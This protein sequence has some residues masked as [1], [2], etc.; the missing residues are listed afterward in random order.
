MDFT[1]EEATEYLRLKRLLRQAVEEQ[2]SES[3]QEELQSQI[4]S[5]DHKRWQM[6]VHA[7]PALAPFTG[8]VEALRYT[9]NAIGVVFPDGNFGDHSTDRF[10]FCISDGYRS[11]QI[12]PQVGSGEYKVEL[13]DYGDLNTDANGRCY[14]GYTASLE[15][16]TLVLCRWLVDRWTIDDLHMRCPWLPNVLLGL[17]QQRL[18]LGNG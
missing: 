16:A 6:I 1:R 15:D 11:V 7:F 14:T 18:F 10:S 2:L 13:F 8:F 4:Q 17:P 9:A 3:Y 5:F 12:W